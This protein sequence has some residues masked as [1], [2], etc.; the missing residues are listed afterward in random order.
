MPPA[1]Q[2]RVSVRKLAARMNAMRRSRP[3]V[4]FAAR[5]ALTLALT[6]A[7]IGTVGYEVMSNQLETRV[8]ERYAG[9]HRADVKGLQQEAKRSQA[10]D[11]RG[12]GIH[13]LDAIAF[14]PGVLE[15]LLI[16][17]RHQVIA[18]HDRGLVGTRDSDSRIDAALGTGRSYAG[19]EADPSLDR[20][21][22]EFVAPVELAGRRYAFETSYDHR[23]FDAELRDLR[24]T[25]ALIGVLG[26]LGGVLVFYLLGGRSLIRSHS[27]ALERATRDGLT[28]LGNQRAFQ[29]EREL[30]VALATRNGDAL[31][32][33]SF[34]LDDFKFLND[35]HGHRHGDD[36]LLRV[37]AILGG[38]RLGDRA[39]RVG[40]DEFALLAPNVDAEG[41]AV[42]ARR[43]QRACAESNISISIG[44][45]ELR[46]GE[47]EE[48]LHAESD[49][50]L[51]EAKRRGGR[52]IVSYAEIREHVSITTPEK[53]GAVRDILSAGHMAVAFQPIWDL[54][55][56][57]L[58]GVEALARPH[59]DYGLSGP[60]EA[61]DIAEQIRRVH[62][63]DALCVKSALSKAHAL[64]AGA[65]LFTNISPQT[66]DTS[67][68]SEEWLAEA[69]SEAG[70]RPVDVVI[71]ITER[72][73]ARTA[74]V[75]KGL[76]RLRAQGFKLALDDV[77]T[78]NSGLEMLRQVN[79]EFVK[80]DRSIVVA[81]LAE[82]GAR[83]VLLAIA[84][85]ARQT[86]AMVI[87][88]GIE[89][90]E[91]LEFIRRLDLQERDT[92]ATIQGAQGYGL[93]RP[94]FAMPTT[95]GLPATVAS[96]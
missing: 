83:G 15:V 94:Q 37:A 28:D 86:G 57:S 56:S 4:G 6:L 66:L 81:A 93:G 27:R 14:R 70:L 63:L 45:S 25:M 68:H 16:D 90:R 91:M 7:V 58:L 71:E 74:S 95:Q 23:F 60:A 35:R 79:V 30:A 19:Q 96:A 41:A 20:R 24:R 21:N 67:L 72:F 18:A 26:L 50:A 64:P 87:A 36:L 39:F 82:A 92:S 62:E 77:G 44:L 75:V 88:E 84:T 40:G 80:I 13:L 10:P 89:D 12:E 52:A 85:F 3:A 42:L 65:L 54:N 33:L 73:G 59:P 31:S 2:A 29:K 53:I 9:E 46:A 69:V 78:G 17:S 34:D 43:L 76:E 11:A 48:A 38:G 51:Y 8:V 32:L 47:D 49:A 55:G 61:F 1:A 5:L 22:F